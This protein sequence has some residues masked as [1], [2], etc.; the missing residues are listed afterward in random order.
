MSEIYNSFQKY[1]EIVIADTH[2]LL[3]IVYR[4][5]YQVF[6]L[7][8]GFL[9]ASAY[10]D[11]RETDDYDDHSAHALLRFRSSGDFVGT[12]RLILFNPS[13]PEKP[14][15]V[16]L[17]TQ[18]DPALCNI[19]LLPRQQV[20]EIS[21][22]LVVKQFDRRRG[23]R[24]KPAPKEPSQ[25]T[26]ATVD[27]RRSSDRRSSDRR[28]TPH[29]SLLLMAS[30]MRMSAKYNIKHWLFA[31]EPALNRLLGFYGLDFNPIGPPVNY[32]GIR[33]PYYMKV[34]DAL[35]KMHSDYYDAWEV[36]TDCG[37]YYPF[38]SVRENI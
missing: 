4:L 27:D 13:Q 6:C 30:V 33:R 19:K 10:P 15:P 5:R 12:V 3:E 36:V 2:E 20:A 29:L 18:I 31:T 26:V 38:P 1:F 34:E 8:H 24:R 23:E 35:N 32:H 25:D 14:F 22:S 37:Q 9:D 7:E 21:R 28:T 11:Q 17:Y 16:E